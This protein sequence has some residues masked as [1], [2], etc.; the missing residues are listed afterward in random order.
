MRRFLVLTLLTR[1][2]LLLWRSMLL[3]FLLLLFVFLLQLLRLLLMALFPRRR[4]RLRQPRPF[5]T[6]P[7]A[8]RRPLWFRRLIAVG[9]TRVLRR[10]Q[11][12]SRRM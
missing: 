12:V 10:P 2:R 3:H 5:A 7:H 6:R 4:V 8:R 1:R 9:R 11:L